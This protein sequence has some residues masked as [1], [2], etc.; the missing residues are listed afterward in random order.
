[1]ANREN[2]SHSDREEIMSQIAPK[3]AIHEDDNHERLPR[4][5]QRRYDALV[6]RGEQARP[7]E[8]RLADR[9]SY[10][11]GR[12][13][14]AFSI[15]IVNERGRR[16][17]TSFDELSVAEAYLNGDIDLDGEMLQ[18][19]KYRAVLT[20][21]HPL[22][23]LFVT[24]LIPF[25][26]GQVASDKRWIKNHYDNDPEF[27][28]LW[29]DK[30]FRGYSQAFFENDAEPLE[31]AMERK[32]RFAFDACRLKPGDRV[33][34]VGGGWGSFNEFAGKQGVRVT[35]LTI[36]A[37]SEK[38]IA[39]LI[40]REQLPC[41]VIKEH[42]LEYQ[43]DEPYDAI[44]NLGVTEHLPDYRSTLRQYQRLLKPGSRIYLDAF[45]GERHG[46]PSF[47]SKWVYEGN[48]SPWYLPQ[49]FTELERTPFEVMQVE[50]DRHSYYLTCRKWA[51]NLEASRDM[52]IGR[53]GQHL[54]RRFHLYLWSAANS[55]LSGTLSAHHMVL[56]LSKH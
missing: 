23:Y 32:F 12:G 49:F 10:L 28:T 27:Y 50:N 52:V 3:V 22:R 48:T 4:T 20:D 14:P 51:E 6:A 31:V 25:F 15:A 43:G 33:L 36:S 35:S 26:A 56:E 13:E 7:F 40:R 19:Y 39:D 44:V 18:V 29:L 42:F 54:Y 30:K 8:L 55:F 17:L 1:M 24:Y 9:S 38:F 53:W 21:R 34:D 5:L 2:E 11:I 16:A 47:I 41:Q 46:M 37:Q 45:S